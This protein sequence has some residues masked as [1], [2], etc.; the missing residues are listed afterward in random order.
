MIRTICALLSLAIVVLLFTCSRLG[1]LT[2]E[3]NFYGAL[4]VIAVC[5]V[6]VLFVLRIRRVVTEVITSEISPDS[7]S[8]LKEG[9]ALL[10]VRG[11]YY[12][13]TKAAP[14]KK[15]K[16]RKPEKD[17]RLTQLEQDL[18]RYRAQEAQ[19]RETQARAD[20]ELE[21]ARREANALREQQ[22]RFA[23]ERGEFEKTSARRAAALEQ[24]ELAVQASEKEA[25]RQL[26]TVSSVR[27]ELETAR[28]S[29]SEALGTSQRR[30]DEIGRLQ[31]EV[32]RLT[33]ASSALQLDLQNAQQLRDQHLQALQAARA[34]LQAAGEMNAQQREAL[35][36]AAKKDETIQ[37]LQAAAEKQGQDLQKLTEQIGQ[38]QTQL[39]TSRRQ[40][41]EAQRLLG[42]AKA[43]ADEQKRQL[44]ARGQ[45]LA[46][47]NGRADA[48]EAKL[49]AVGATGVEVA[50]RASLIRQVIAGKGDGQLAA[51]YKQDYP[52]SVQAFLS[53]PFHEIEM[54]A[55]SRALG[56]G[57][58]SSDTDQAA[59]LAIARS[60]INFIGSPT[61]A[62]WFKPPVL[63]MILSHSDKR[64][65]RGVLLSFAADPASANGC[66]QSDNIIAAAYALPL[67]LRALVCQAAASQNDLASVCRIVFG[68][69]ALQAQA[70][71]LQA[72]LA[73]K[74]DHS[75][76]PLY[77]RQYTDLIRRSEIDPAALSAAELLTYLDPDLLKRLCQA[78]SFKPGT[79]AEVN[80]MALTGVEPHV[81]LLLASKLFEKPTEARLRRLIGLIKVVAEL[82]HPAV[83]RPEG[84]HIGRVSGTLDLADPYGMLVRLFVDS[85]KSASNSSDAVDK[86]R[87][88]MLG[89]VLSRYC[90]QS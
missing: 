12:A 51:V 87:A 77:V 1:V 56:E 73:G 4:L 30:G 13:S 22:Q 76:A 38:L 35:G 2:L 78:V 67:P 21:S 7:R 36:A 44:E 49:T 66:L 62:C 16:E 9:L 84:R 39:E 86:L 41:E 81:A 32:R 83:I 68:E 57:A 27:G 69:P 3:V 64:T 24:R 61:M 17:P 37:Q 80:C 5:A 6:A 70:K 72:A 65:A 25:E 31:E 29:L 63:Q 42:E 15:K 82:E 58:K 33:S 47:A 28:R 52:L 85:C 74:G 59:L 50:R 89:R 60:A 45:E 11:K 48:A 79:A 34:E 75:A 43:A 40:S 8:T 18:E 14:P 54:A 53:L 20:R 88:H 19:T 46:A 23:Q 55:L 90:L 71:A 10:F 26:G